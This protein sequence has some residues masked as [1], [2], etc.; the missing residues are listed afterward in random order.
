MTDYDV[1]FIVRDGSVGCTSWFNN[2]VFIII[3]IITIIIIKEMRLKD[4]PKIRTT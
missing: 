1:R 2:T 3:I 4:A